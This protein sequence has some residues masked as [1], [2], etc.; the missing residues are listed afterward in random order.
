MHNDKI[1][2]GIIL[3][4][5]DGDRLG[6]LTGILPKVLL[7]VNGKEQLIRC[8]IEALVAAGV[9]DIAIVIGYLGDRVIEALGN[10]AEFGVRLQYV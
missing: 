6:S 9:S 8:P 5:G 4:A 3:A 7:P 2:K 1:N 10:G